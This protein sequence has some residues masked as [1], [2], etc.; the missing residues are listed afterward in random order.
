MYT[1]NAE[2]AYEG[3]KEWPR[4]CLGEANRRPALTL[5][6]HVRVFA[7]GE[8]RLT[9]GSARVFRDPFGASTS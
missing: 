3:E 2:Y 1:I 6:G 9:V 4:A 7:K 8:G 5:G